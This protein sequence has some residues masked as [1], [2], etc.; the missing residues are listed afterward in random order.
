MVLN[1]KL[2]VWNANDFSKRFKEKKTALEVMDEWE[3]WLGENNPLP[4]ADSEVPPAK[5][6]CTEE[7]RE[8]DDQEKW[9]D[10]IDSEIEKHKVGMFIPIDT[11]SGIYF[12]PRGGGGVTP[13]MPMCSFVW[14][15]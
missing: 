4:A 5:R 10:D 8:P 1:R 11:P 6:I 7:G 15:E 13:C 2:F 14:E 3:T 9:M 12:C